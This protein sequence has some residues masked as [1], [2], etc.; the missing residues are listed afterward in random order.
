MGLR[1]RGVG[2]YVMARH[3]DA[4]PYAPW[5]VKCIRYE[6]NSREKL[7]N[8]T[9]GGG[10][11]KEQ[12]GERASHVKLTEAVVRQ[13]RSDSRSSRALAAALGIPRSTLRDARFGRTWQHV[14]C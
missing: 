8:G 12:R 7:Q 1:G 6:D 13:I 2:K 11:S 9:H 14:G 4:G 3:G 5:N 10:R